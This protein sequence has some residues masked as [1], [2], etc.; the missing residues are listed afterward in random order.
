MGRG[1]PRRYADGEIVNGRRVVGYST[2]PWN[3]YIV[4][5]VAC[6]KTTR[7]HATNIGRTRCQRCAGSARAATSRE[8]VADMLAGGRPVTDVARELGLSK[9]RISQIAAMVADPL[10]GLT[11]A[12]IAAAA[13]KALKRPAQL[14]LARVAAALPKE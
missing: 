14:R 11:D 7:S 5:C 4:A 2:D 8:R 3:C 1:M 6:G 10:A 9:Q 12:Q 13:R